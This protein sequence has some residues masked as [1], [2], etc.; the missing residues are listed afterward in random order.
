MKKLISLLRAVM[1]Q[2]MDLFKVKTND[3]GK[4]TKILIP[5]FLG[6]MIMF[7]AGFYAYMLAE[8]LSL[9]GLTF[10]V[11]TLFILFT[12]IL[13]LLEGIYKSQGILFD[14][15]DNDLL[16]SLPISKSRVLF[17]RLF[18]M[19][20]FEFI[21]NSL[22]LLPAIIVY[23]ILETP[24]ISFYIISFIMLLL[25]PIIPT[26]VASII[27]YIIKGISS[28]SKIKNIIQIV[29]SSVL[30]LAVF[31][32][33]YN[34]DSFIENIA[35]NATS[36]NE[37]ITK[38]YYPAGLYIDLIQE[39]KI[40]DIL[41]LFAVSIIPAII[42]IYFASLYYFK[43]ISHSSERS[44]SNNRSKKSNINNLKVRKPIGALISKEFK[45]FLSSPVF[46]IN[47]GFGLV[48][49]IA[50]SCGLIFNSNAIIDALLDTF[51]SG[52][53]IEEI[54]DLIPKLFY[55]IV[56]F[57]SCTTSITSSLISI[58][59]KSFYVTKSLPLSTKNILLSKILMSNLIVI[60][61]IFI[62]DIIFFAS[63]SLSLLDLM[64]IILATILFPTFTSLVGLIMNL[65]YPNMNA[66]S[67]TEVVKQS[68]SATVSA[69]I[70]VLV[71][72]ASIGIIVMGSDLNLTLIIGI[73]LLI[74]T[75]VIMILWNVLKTY[76]VKKWNEI[77]V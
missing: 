38:V 65:K 5:L 55:G 39:F 66:S 46:V 34:L 62:C 20:L 44:R 75:I 36:I 21:Y 15:K 19:L 13:T 41:L 51:G 22:F 71:G 32:G 7:S 2:D 27:G 58:E 18:K 16:L 72:M 69:F 23:A 31:F 12:S 70:G 63:F 53:S 76:G 64:Y 67:D 61:I 17:V 40:T 14:S 68:W 56:V 48:I 9:V 73:E 52:V 59:G 11:L 37:V 29:L 43:I 49:M 74:V 24:T 28:K 47:A 8:K 33:S 10:I 30:L 1:S 60:P 3:S 4:I 50:A 57:A 6:I 77:N 42:F 35:E 45:R 26:I 54:K 25:S